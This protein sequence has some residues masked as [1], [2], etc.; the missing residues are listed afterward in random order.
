MMN[1]DYP[2]HLLEV[3]VVD[4]LST[5]STLATVA[6]VGEAHSDVP[7]RVLRNPAGIV[8]TGM[9]IGILAAQGEVIVRVDG[10][11]VIAADYVSECVDALRRTDATTVGGGM[12]V[13]A[14][15]PVERAVAIAT[16]CWFGVGGSKFH[17]AKQEEYV[18]TVYMGAWRSSAFTRFGLFD[19]EQVRAQ[20]SEMNYRIRKLGGTIFLTPRIQS[21]YYPRASFP[22]LAKQYFQYGFWRV[23][24]MQKHPNQ[25][26]VRQALPA[27]FLCLVALGVVLALIKG[28]W[29]LLGLT[30]GGYLVL[31]A[32]AA[33]SECII[34]KELRNVRLVLV[35]FFVMHYSY[36][37][38]SAIGLLRWSTCSRHIV[39]TEA[40]I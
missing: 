11:T 39:I 40:K 24:V 18:D 21:R 37:I 31:A 7:L 9:N 19:E 23:R 16:S 32:S 17:F 20:D 26:K 10:H 15:T 4:G 3:I 6:Q 33:A 27:L 25:A 34:R 12:V 29:W 8:P 2:H 13:V 5:D 35:A 38:G 28:F 30:L 1:Q 36:A 14:N 22:R